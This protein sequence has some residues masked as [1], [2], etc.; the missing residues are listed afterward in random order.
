MC[1]LSVFKSVSVCV[2]VLSSRQ[3]PRLLSSATSPTSLPARCLTHCSTWFR[4]YYGKLNDKTLWQLR[5]GCDDDVALPLRLP[6]LL[7]PSCGRGWLAFSCG[8]CGNKWQL[9]AANCLPCEQ[10]TSLLVRPQEVQFKLQL[11]KFVYPRN[12]SRGI[13]STW[14]KHLEK[15]HTTFFCL[16]SLQLSHKDNIIYISNSLIADLFP[17]EWFEDFCESFLLVFPEF[18]RL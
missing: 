5:I 16:Y 14:L 17:F 15:A 8:M 10:L 11:K 3:S 2:C 1:C 12:Y 13:Y 4:Y 9:N 18:S 6:H 7:A